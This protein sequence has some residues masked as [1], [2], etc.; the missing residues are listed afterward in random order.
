MG[1]MHGVVGTGFP[2]QWLPGACYARFCQHEVTRPMVAMHRVVM[3]GVSRPSFARHRFCRLIVTRYS[4]ARHR[5]PRYGFTSFT[6]IVIFDLVKLRSFAS[7]D[8]FCTGCGFI[9][10]PNLPLGFCG[11]SLLSD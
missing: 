6:I 11:F 7:R 1:A 3:N 9:I 8:C 2:G 4:V 5:V 10:W